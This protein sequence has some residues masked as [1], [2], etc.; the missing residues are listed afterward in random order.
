MTFKD[1]RRRISSSNQ[2]QQTQSLD[3]LQNK[4]FWIWDVQEHKL[5]DI[6]TKGECCFNHIIGLPTKDGLEKPIF[7]YREFHIFMSKLE[8]E[9][10]AVL[11]Y[12]VLMYGFWNRDK[13]IIG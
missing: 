5:E 4:T 12:P 11:S 13:T 8:V 2:Q 3:K 10:L 9:H 7:D 6:R 1:L